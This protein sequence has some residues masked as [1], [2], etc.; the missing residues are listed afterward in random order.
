MKINIIY[1]S[2]T[3]NTEAMAELIAKGAKGAGADVSLIPVGDASADDLASCD[4]AALGC[5]SM[6][7]EILEEGEFQPYIDSI[8]DQVS[9]KKIGLFGSYGWGDGEWM[10]NW[11]QSMKDAGAALAD[12]GLIVNEAPDG[13][14]ADRCE[15]FGKLLAGM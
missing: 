7:D 12:D 2:G 11:C 14:E 1:W 9:G 15:A 8:M 3:G 4:V 10:R 13:D 5:P 6:G